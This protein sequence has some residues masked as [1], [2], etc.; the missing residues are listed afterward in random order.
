MNRV[1]YFDNAS[2]IDWYLQDLANGL[3]KYFILSTEAKPRK[4]MKDDFIDPGCSYT[5]HQ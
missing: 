4:K 2:R 1:E 3:A 5:C